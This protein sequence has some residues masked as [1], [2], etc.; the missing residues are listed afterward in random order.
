MTPEYQAQLKRV[1]VMAIPDL[2][3][4]DNNSLALKAVLNRL[5]EVEA[6]IRKHRDQR[7]DDRC[8]MDDQE[9]YAVVGE[10]I[11]SPLPPK[12]E[13]LNN[14]ERFW[15]CRQHPA[16]K[17]NADNVSESMRAALAGIAAT[18]GL[19]T[20]DDL[21][22]DVPIGNPT[23]TVEAVEKAMNAR[24]L[25]SFLRGLRAGNVVAGKDPDELPE[26]GTPCEEMRG[27]AR[28]DSSTGIFAVI[29]KA[30][31][32]YWDE[33]RDTKIALSVGVFFEL[34][35]RIKLA[36][37]KASAEELQLRVSSAGQAGGER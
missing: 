5:D 36:L 25:K 34:A 3:H 37:Q 31:E 26:G 10:P 6:A 9:L 4:A 11:I 21:P 20:W 30:T 12:K 24:E 22:H 19:D 2:G 1:R 17:Y 33:L 15:E 18:L 23:A 27:N 7:G 8:W 32:G 29:D 14:C 35:E 16:L 13:F 28:S